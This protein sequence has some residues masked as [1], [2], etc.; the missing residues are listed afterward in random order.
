MRKL[1]KPA[2]TKKKQDAGRTSPITEGICKATR[3]R[4]INW[5]DMTDDE[6]IKFAKKFIEE[7]KI[8]GRT[9]LGREYQGI[10]LILRKRGLINRLELEKDRSD[11]ASLNSDELVAYAEKFVE[12]NEIARRSGNDG[13]S[14]M[15][16][17][18]YQ[19]LRTRRDK[20]GQ[21]LLD[22]I[23]FSEG[24]VSWQDKSNEELVETA[25]MEMSRLGVESST[26]LEREDRNLYQ[27]LVKRG[28][29]GEVGF[30]RKYRDWK[31][32]ENP[33]LLEMCKSLVEA[34]NIRNRSELMGANS[35]L[36]RELER[37]KLLDAAGFALR[38]RFWKGVKDEELVARALDFTKKER[39][40]S[41]G[42]LEKA[43]LGLYTELRKRGLLGELGLSPKRQYW[44]VMSDDELLGHAWTEIREHDIKQRSGLEKIK[45]RLYATLKS[46]GLIDRLFDEIRLEEDAEGQKAGLSEI[47]D[48]LSEFGGEE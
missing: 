11:W 47:S 29:T 31:E 19:A 4:R 20:D 7:N 35:G 36:Y 45:H 39:I 32:I 46:R 44:H 5:S 24:L 40:G 48:A 42:E 33:D 12:E 9:E 15:N 16:G 37:R 34:R 43:D 13:L 25:K 22:R 18:L 26:E 28:L 41:R 10:Y 17:G 14:S 30:K 1:R 38:K 3:P 8:K 6:I 2:A 23:E 21:R 27:A